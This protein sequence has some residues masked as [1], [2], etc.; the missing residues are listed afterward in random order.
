MSHISVI[1]ITDIIGVLDKFM[2]RHPISYLYV[3]N[4]VQN[5][6]MERRLVLLCDSNYIV[7]D[8]RLCIRIHLDEGIW[9]YIMVG[10][11]VDRL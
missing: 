6:F 7:K 1:D 5:F 2:D 8:A 9:A 4:L 10:V 11:L 3:I